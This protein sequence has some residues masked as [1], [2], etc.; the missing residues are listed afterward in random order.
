MSS[1]Y[2][3][4]NQYDPKASMNYHGPNLKTNPKYIQLQRVESEIKEFVILKYYLTLVF[5][6]I[7]GGLVVELISGSPEEEAA[8]TAR[9]IAITIR[10]IQIL[11]YGYGLTAYSSRSRLQWQIFCI[12]VFLSFGIIAYFLIMSFNEKVWFRFG[13]NIFNI[14]VNL[15]LLIYCKKFYDNLKKRDTL[16]ALLKDEQAAFDEKQKLLA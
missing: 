16:K 15:W 1:D 10:V 2:V 6:L 5:M 7:I 9:T 11:G 8:K 4:P 3:P 12:Y 14:F 13:F